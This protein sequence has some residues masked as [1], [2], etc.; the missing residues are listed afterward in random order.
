MAALD[1]GCSSCSPARLTGGDDRLAG[2]DRNNG[3]VWIR[4]PINEILAKFRMT[5]G[6]DWNII[7]IGQTDLLLE[8][9]DKAKAWLGLWGHRRNRLRYLGTHQSVVHKRTL[10]LLALARGEASK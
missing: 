10:H 6:D 1:D 7:D 9:I 2:V 3:S 8:A 4:K 5:N